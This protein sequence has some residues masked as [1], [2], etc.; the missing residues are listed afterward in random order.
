MRKIKEV[1]R[2]KY[3]LKLGQRQIARSCAVGLATVNDYLARAERAG[4]GWPLPE[5]WGEPELE[6][7]LFGT[8]AAARRPQRTTPD[9]ATIHQQRRTQRSVTLQL[10][11]EEYREANPEGYRYSRFCELYQRWRRKLD[12][13]M[14]QEHKPGEKAFIDWAGSTIPIY[15]RAT[16]VDWQ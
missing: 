2:L 12:V 11:W 7:A 14:R 5:G 6:A 15:D 3:E 16:G 8:E 9:F 13:V 1:L 10:L 4:I